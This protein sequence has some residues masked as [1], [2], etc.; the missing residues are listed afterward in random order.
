M[1]LPLENYKN[2]FM[3]LALPEMPLLLSEPASAPRTVI[4]YVVL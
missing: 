4:K 1:T 2:A 3:N